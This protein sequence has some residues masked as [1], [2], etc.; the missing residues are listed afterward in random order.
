V[1]ALGVCGGLMSYGASAD[2]ASPPSAS[3]QR[4]DP[5]REKILA[6]LHSP[7]HRDRRRG[8]IA[9][10]RQAR[11]QTMPRR[12]RCSTASIRPWTWRDVS[13]DN[14][15]AFGDG[16]GVAKWRL[17]KDTSASGKGYFVGDKCIICGDATWQTASK[18]LK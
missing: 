9:Y 13:E 10:E 16:S 5:A 4:P 11:L 6:G 7:D 14:G 1:A 12:F 18:S 15:G 3:E 17:M 2:R 8:D